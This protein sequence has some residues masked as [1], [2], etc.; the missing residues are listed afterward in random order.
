MENGKPKSSEDC[1]YCQRN[2]DMIRKAGFVVNSWMWKHA[3]QEVVEC[4]ATIVMVSAK[5]YKAEVVN[6]A[7]DVLNLRN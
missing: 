4:A 2:L 1:A 7:M 6:W 5:N 3:R